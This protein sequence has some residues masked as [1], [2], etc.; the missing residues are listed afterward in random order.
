MRRRLSITTLAELSLAHSLYGACD[1]CRHINAL[2]AGLLR[3]QFGLAATLDD[4]R[5]RLK[6][7]RCGARRARLMISQGGIGYW[8]PPPPPRD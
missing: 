2:D 3:R 1:Q 5:H 7:T 8:H 4:V 6:C